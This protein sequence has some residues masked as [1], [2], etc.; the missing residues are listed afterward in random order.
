MT[1]VTSSESQVIGKRRIHKPVPV[2]IRS[3]N[4]IKSED[5]KVN[6]QLLNS[7]LGKWKIESGIR[8]KVRECWLSFRQNRLKD[9]LAKDH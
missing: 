3:V 2:A 6:I 7:S 1:C 9:I 4:K 8:I 5:S